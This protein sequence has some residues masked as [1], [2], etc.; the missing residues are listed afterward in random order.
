MIKFPLVNK[1]IKFPFNFFYIN[2]TLCSEDF[3]SA[4]IRSGFIMILL[5]LRAAVLSS[6]TPF[7]L[8]LYCYNNIFLQCGF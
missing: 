3:I 1:V 8:P 4:W 5:L 2:K 6:F 7:F